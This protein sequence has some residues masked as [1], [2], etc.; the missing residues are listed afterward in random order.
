MLRRLF[1]VLSALSLLLCVATAALWIDGRVVGKR[2]GLFG[3]PQ[4]GLMLANESEGML[5]VAG[6]LLA[7][8]L[9]PTRMDQLDFAPAFYYRSIQAPFRQRLLVVSHWFAV[10]V[11]ALPP[12]AWLGVRLLSRRARRRD[13]GL[14]PACGYDLRATPGR[15]PEC[16]TVA[17]A[18][19]KA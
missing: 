10:A 2:S 13:R 16:G 6:D 5:L 14:C 19:V 9:R 18:D 17:A 4:D 12:A 8:R 15:C 1:T 7:T 3:T 11:T